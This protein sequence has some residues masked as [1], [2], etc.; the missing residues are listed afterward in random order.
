MA[1]SGPS[2]SLPHQRITDTVRATTEQSMPSKGA[3]GIFSNVESRLSA[4]SNYET[5]HAHCCYDEGKDNDLHYGM[6]RASRSG[7]RASIT[8]HEGAV[9][10]K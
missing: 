9:S 8:E 7:V 3:R 10:G 6:H 1:A 4:P 5:S 2:L